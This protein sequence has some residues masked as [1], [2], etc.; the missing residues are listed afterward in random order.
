MEIL[1][2]L[3]N[4]LWT[5]LFQV[6]TTLH[7]ILP[8]S[9]QILLQ[10]LLSTLGIVTYVS[11]IL[12]APPSFPSSGN[13]LWYTAPGMIWTE[14]WLPIGNGYLGAMLPGGTSQEA[15]QL[16]IESLWS[17]GPFQDPSYNGGNH[18]PSQQA[19]IAENMQSIR[20]AIFS[21]STG[22]IDNID[23]IMTPSGTYGSYAS[24]GHLLATLNSSGSISNYARWLD[25]DEGVS[26]T[27]WSDGSTTF[28]RESFCSHPLQAC[29]QYLNSTTSHVLPALTYA[30]TVAAVD[31]LP[32]P[33]VTCLDD[34][35]LSIRNYV[36]I[37]GM[38]YEILVQAQA[39]GG[40][41]SCSAVPGSI[42]P[43]ATLTVVGASEAWGPDPHNNL[44]TLLSSANLTSYAEMLNGHIKDY[45]SI[46][47]RFSL[48]L[49]QTPDL[50]TP[51]D[52]ILA[53]YQ[54]S[55]GNAYLEWVL[56]N[57]GRYLLASS[58]RGTLPA[59]LQGI[60][61]D[62]YSNPWGADSNINIQMNYW[63]AEMTNLDVTQSLFDYIQNTWGPRGAYT[64]QV[65]YNIS[66]GFVTHGE[67]NIFGHT[68]MKLGGN[69]AQWANY[70][71]SNAWM[72]IHAWD[73]F[74]HTNDVQWWKTQGWPLVKSVASFHLEKLIE[75]LYFND[76]TLV[77]APCNSPEQVP[78]TLGC[79]HAQQLIWQ[80]F[81]AIE[82]GFEAAG[83]TDTAFLDAIISKRQQMDKGLRIGRWGQLQEW[84]VDMDTPDDTHRHLSHLIGLYPGYAIASYSPVFQGG[85]IVNGTFMNYTKEQLLNAAETSLIHRGIGRGPDADAGWEKIW[86]AAA[87]AQLANETEFYKELT[88]AIETNFAPN[89]F[90][91]YTSGG[92]FQIDANLGYPAAVLNALLQAPD[93]QNIKVPLQVTLLPALPPTWSAGEM[94]GARI[95][96]GITL[97]LAWNEGKP[98]T[99]TF[100]VDQDIAGRE[101]DVLVNYGGKVVAEFR[102]N[103]GY[104][105][106]VS[107]F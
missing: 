105:Q 38:L 49:G 72:M 20:G 63:P 42:P 27:T 57:Y 90:D 102:S 100:T 25:L 75:D 3:E 77:T 41:V 65:L 22:T 24:A 91:L 101:R 76:L 60:W 6:S 28:L 5:C 85:L 7:G 13:G 71:E 78:I 30:Y 89:L 9:V 83:D 61:A 36:S 62:G 19:R 40:L 48:S 80:L 99:A 86:R 53:G 15:T 39:P 107:S 98:T 46:V 17:G 26:R 74:D 2:V 68:G 16:N 21:S 1:Q 64:A 70:P 47:T 52:Q 11:S 51:T 106:T 43:N 4:Y 79:A 97:D 37:P 84:K 31:G 45:T 81:N 95:R 18:L 87:W 92:I 66:E 59:N 54:T 12:S 29:V 94:R 10:H 67:M 73:H 35:T 82:N 23:E 50:N 93:V 58:A 104:T 8:Y 44:V 14:E 88:H 69:S 96:G 55:V 56:F 103:G 33:N 34:T 32:A